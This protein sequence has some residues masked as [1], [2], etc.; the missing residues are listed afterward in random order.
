MRLAI[1]QL[2]GRLMSH[3]L[4]KNDQLSVA[5]LVKRWSF[6]LSQSSYPRFGAMCCINVPRQLRMLL[7]LERKI[8]I[9][10]KFNFL[11]F[12]LHVLTVDWA[13][14]NNIH[15]MFYFG[16]HTQHP[17]VASGCLFSHFSVKRKKKFLSSYVRPL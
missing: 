9:I 7:Q 5:M 8:K 3:M 1:N 12:F 16:G 11:S 4:S 17:L 10:D 14:E 15:Q 6:I 2:S 13:H